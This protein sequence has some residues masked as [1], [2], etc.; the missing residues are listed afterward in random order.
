MSDHVLAIIGIVATVIL[1]LIGLGVAALTVS[2]HPDRIKTAKI[3]FLR[4]CNRLHY[5]YILLDGFDDSWS[6]RSRRN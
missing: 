6:T 5:G 4:R 1:A 2:N 3:F